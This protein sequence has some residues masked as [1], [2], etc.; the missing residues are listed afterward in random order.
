MAPHPRPAVVT[1]AEEYVRPTR[2]T[3][4]DAEEKRRI[5][6]AARAARDE[7]YNLGKL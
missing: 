4:R 2:R 3:K 7:L 5:Q 1:P 6:M